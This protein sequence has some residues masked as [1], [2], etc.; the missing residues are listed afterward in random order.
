MKLL[1]IVVVACV[2]VLILHGHTFACTCGPTPPTPEQEFNTSTAVFTGQVIQVFQNLD[3][4]GPSTAL[5]IVDDCWKGVTTPL[6][7]VYTPGTGACCGIDFQLTQY[8]FYARDD[9][10]LGGP[11]VYLCGRT[12]YLT[13][14]GEDLA[15][16][17]ISNCT[18][19]VRDKTWGAIK[20]LYGIDGEIN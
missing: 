1:Q 5:V 10:S 17:G 7:M 13:G 2:G 8:I 15:Y 19:P 14:A 20:S 9:A 12:G 11:S 4:E 18:V 16:L 3:C 6:L